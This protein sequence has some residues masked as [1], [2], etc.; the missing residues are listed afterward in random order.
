MLPDLDI[1]HV[2]AP[3]TLAANTRMSSEMTAEATR[4]VILTIGGQTVRGR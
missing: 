4:G 1:D 3:W 2:A